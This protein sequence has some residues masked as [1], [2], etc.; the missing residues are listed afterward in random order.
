MARANQARGSRNLPGAGSSTYAD[1]LYARLPNL[2]RA[3]FS[4]QPEVLGCATR[5]LTGVPCVGPT[6]VLAEDVRAAVAAVSKLGFVGLTERW[7]ESVCLFHRTF[8]LPRPKRA[9]ALNS[10]AGNIYGEAERGAARDPA[11]EAVYAEAARVFAARLRERGAAASCVADAEAL[12]VAPPRPGKKTVRYDEPGDE[13]PELPPLDWASAPRAWRF[14]ERDAAAF[15]RFDRAAVARAFHEPADPTR[16]GARATTAGGRL[17]VEYARDRDLM[18]VAHWYRVPTFAAALLEVLRRAPDLPAVDFVLLP[19]DVP[20]ITRAGDPP[21]FAE[22]RSR[23]EPPGA[24]QWLLPSFD[25]F[26]LEGGDVG[27]VAP[28]ATREASGAYWRG[29]VRLFYGYARGGFVVARKALMSLGQDAVGGDALAEPV[30][31]RL[32]F[33]GGAGTWRRWTVST[34]CDR[35]DGRLDLVEPRG[36]ELSVGSAS[37]P[38]RTSLVADVKELRATLLADAAGGSA[39]T[40]AKLRNYGFGD[41]GAACAKEAL[42]Y[43]DGISTSNGLKYYLACGVPVLMDE[44]ATFEDL[45]TAA[46]ASTTPGGRL[47]PGVDYASVGRRGDTFRGDADAV[48][49]LERRFCDDVAGAVDGLRA[50]PAAAAAMGQRGRAAALEVG[51]AAA[52]LEYLELALRAYARLQNFGAPP[53]GARPRLRDGRGAPA[54]ARETRLDDDADV[55]HAY[56][57]LQI[58]LLG[59]GD[60]EPL[61]APA[62]GPSNASPRPGACAGRSATPPVVVAGQSVGSRASAVAFFLRAAG[63]RLNG[64]DDDGTNSAART[65]VAKT[66]GRDKG[67]NKARRSDAAAPDPVDAAAVALAGFDGLRTLATAG[68]LKSL[69]YDVEELPPADRRAELAA[70]CAFALNVSALAAGDGPWGWRSTRNA[71]HLP[72]F[73]VAFP[74][75][76]L[77]HVVRDVR[78]ITA[79]GAEGAPDAWRR[80]GLPVAFAPAGGVSAGGRCDRVYGGVV[81]WRKTFEAFWAEQQTALAAAGAALGPARYRLARVED[82]AA[83]DAEADAAVAW[84]LGDNPPAPGARVAAFGGAPEPAAAPHACD[85]LVDGV[86]EGRGAAFLPTQLRG[87]GRAP[88]SLAP[89]TSVVDFLRE[90][91]AWSSQDDA[92]AEAFFSDVA[93]GDGGER[94]V[95]LKSSFARRLAAAPRLAAV[96]AVKARCADGHRDLAAP[97]AAALDALGYAATVDVAARAYAARGAATAAQRLYA[98]VPAAS[99][100][101]GD[102]AAPAVPPASK[103]GGGRRRRGRRGKQGG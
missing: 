18:G 15:S 27:D 3:T 75:F 86:F 79:P 49:A 17:F 103:G 102:D 66:A 31:R 84:A 39:P 38:Q 56:A 77:L 63:L 35:S 93:F 37:E 98:D 16:R 69:L 6:T 34:A 23:R 40:N 54:A 91:G 52:A 100:C 12:A 14:L 99:Y 43:L 45:I 85:V 44:A 5:M 59:D 57:E 101:A 36:V 78:R 68:R 42:L 51:S 67:A 2:T 24:R 53:G 96:A 58:V 46:W 62:A 80:Y 95:E 41:H 83:G 30:D 70:A 94:R 28:A 22:A 19:M 33:S 26:R 1:I 81:A 25:T 64:L 76:R 7:T 73:Q 71:F 97:V 29:T 48:A 60:P 90:A 65:V 8:G 10:R 13:A 82:L 74:G 20:G 92:A 21:L 89:E 72:A 47:R 50:D 55:R 87:I 11:D 32:Q 4:E 9:Q 61:F 88:L